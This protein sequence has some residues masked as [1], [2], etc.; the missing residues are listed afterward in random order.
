MIINAIIVEDEE[1]AA[2]RLRR[3]IG[4]VAT[5][6]HILEHFEKVSETVHYLR[7]SA[8][9]V[10]LIFLDI[11]LADGNSFEI[12]EQMEV[13]TPIIF[14]TAYDQ[15]ALEAFRQ[16]SIDYLLKPIQGNDL[17]RSL[18]KFRQ[19]AS[20]PPDYTKL[21]AALQQENQTPKKRFLVSAGTKIRSVKVEQ[22]AIFYAANK[23]TFLLTQDG[24][25]YDINYTLEKLVQQLD[26]DTFFRANRKCFL[27]ID[28]IKEVYPFSKSKLKVELFQHP[29][30]DVYIPVERISAFKKWLNR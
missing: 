30:F 8:A 24:K 17:D 12:F 23:A 2:K 27:H 15:Y 16:T 6:I 11:H 26:E 4:E 7:K 21:L 29:G 25:R 20:P 19:L 1:L 22:V 10:D 13:R 3:L 28:N 14:T 9:E 18:E 5:D